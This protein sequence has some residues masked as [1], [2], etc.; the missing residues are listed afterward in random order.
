MRYIKLVGP[1]GPRTKNVFVFSQIHCPKENRPLCFKS[2]QLFKITFKNLQFSSE[3]NC[4]NLG[5]DQKFSSD[6]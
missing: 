6:P 1:V 4:L 2:L 3:E 5:R